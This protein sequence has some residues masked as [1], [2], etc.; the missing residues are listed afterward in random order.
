MH[1]GRLSNSVSRR[2][3]QCKQKIITL[4]QFCTVLPCGHLSHLWK[5]LDL[6]ETGHPLPKKWRQS[7]I[8]PIFQWP[9]PSNR[10]ESLCNG[11]PH[12]LQSLCTR[13][14]PLLEPGNKLAMSSKDSVTN[15]ISQLKA[16]DQTAAQKLWDR[17]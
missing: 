13:K 7:G 17:Y 1:F 15:W 8:S 4:D 10:L 9:E 14:H 6:R 5:C 12:L 11:R 3:R 2:N 16:G